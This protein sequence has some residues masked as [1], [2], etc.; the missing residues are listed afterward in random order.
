[1][2]KVLMITIKIKFIFTNNLTFNFQIF[3]LGVLGKF[4]ELKAREFGIGGVS[5]AGVYSASGKGGVSY[6]NS[7][8]LLYIFI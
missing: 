5:F 7:S 4:P 8:Y 2:Y 6:K 1:M 3:N